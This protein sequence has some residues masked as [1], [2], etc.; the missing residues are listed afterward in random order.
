MNDLLI[1]NKKRRI[2]RSGDNKVVIKYRKELSPLGRFC[3]LMFCT[4]AVFFT[5]KKYFLNQASEDWGAEI[6]RIEAS[7]NQKIEQLRKEKN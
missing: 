7:Y 3:V 1:Q 2:R 4:L 5:S 6:K